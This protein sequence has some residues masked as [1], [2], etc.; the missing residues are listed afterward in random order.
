MF[1][2]TN[3]NNITL[4]KGKWADWLGGNITFSNE[5]EIIDTHATC[6][7]DFEYNI[8]S[9]SIYGSKNI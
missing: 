6:S 4:F 9:C 8:M 2:C 1:K 5:G 7:I 3:C